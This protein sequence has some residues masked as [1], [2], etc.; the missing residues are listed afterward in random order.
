MLKCGVL[1]GSDGLS[2]SMKAFESLFREENQWQLAISYFEK[3]KHPDVI[4]YNS[5]I[6]GLP[7]AQWQSA[8]S[9][10]SDAWDSLRSP[11][12]AVFTRF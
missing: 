4:S 8:L 11:K 3:L 9:L 10:L 6:R 5:V 2:K 7:L 1:M 12:T